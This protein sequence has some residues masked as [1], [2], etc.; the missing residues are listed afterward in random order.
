MG[1]FIDLRQ[2]NDTIKMFSNR[3][4]NGISSTT[5]EDAWNGSAS[6]CVGEVFKI[7]EKNGN[8]L[9]ID[10]ILHFTY[11]PKLNLELKIK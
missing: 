9:I 4:N 2:D 5:F 6:D 7:L 3:V 1:D 8:I 11:D 10:K